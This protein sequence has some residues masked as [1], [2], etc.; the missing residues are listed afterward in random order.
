[1]PFVSFVTVSFDRDIVTLVET[2]HY[3][4]LQEPEWVHVGG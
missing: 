3:P 2:S 4:S 1:M